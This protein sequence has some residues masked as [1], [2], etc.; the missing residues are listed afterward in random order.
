MQIIRVIFLLLIIV[1]SG[2]QH[3]HSQVTTTPS[4]SACTCTGSMSYINSTA[5]SA[6]YTLISNSGAVIS[7]DT[8]TSGT[9]GVNNLCPEV[10]VLTITQNGNTST[11]P[12]NI[13]AGAFNPGNAVSLQLCNTI[14]LTNLNNNVPGLAGGGTWTRPGGVTFSGIVNPSIDP[15]GLYTY[16]VIQGG[17]AVST[18]V[19]ISIIQNANPGQ[20]TTYLICENYVPFQML[21]FMAGSPD[22]G[23]QWFAPGGVPMN[24]IF[25]PATMNTT[26]FTYMI[27]NVPGCNPVFATMYVVENTIPNTGTDAEVLVCAGGT[28]FNMN[29]YLG[30][31]PTS[32][33]VWY[34]SSNQVVSSTFNPATQP[35]GVYRYTIDAATP[36]VDQNSFLTITFT[37]NNPSG[38][39]GSVQLCQNAPA[40]DMTSQLGGAPVP[41]G[42]WTNSSGQPV[43]NIFNPATQSSGVFNYSFQS[44]GCTPNSAQLTVSVEPL[45]NAGLNN[46]VTLCESQPNLN[47]NT[48]LSI[49]TTAGGNWLNSAGNVINPNLT[50]PAGNN[51]LSFSYNVNGVNCPGDVS[52]FTVNIQSAPLPVGDESMGLCVNDDP[53]A[54]NALYP[55]FP[56]I[57]FETTNNIPASNSFDPA[58]PG[59]YTF[60]AINPSGNVCP[61]EQGTLNITVEQPAFQSGAVSFDLCESQQTFDLNTSQQGI[62][63]PNGLWTDVAGNNIS[64]IVNLNFTGAA[65]YIFTSAQSGSC[66]QSTLEVNLNV[67][68]YVEAGA[69]SSVTLCSDATPATLGSLGGITAA[70]G[71]WFYNNQPVSFDVFDPS[72]NAAG[73][74]LYQIPANGPCPAS[75]AQLN[76]A[77][78]NGLQFSTGPDVA[79]CN[80]E[81]SVQIGQQNPLI[82]QYNWQPAQNLNNTSIA[83]PTFTIPAAGNN[84]TAYSYSVIATDGI[85][86]AV[87]TVNITVYPHPE[88]SL[89]PVYTIC[90]GETVMWQLAVGNTYNWSPSSLFTD[91]SSPIQQIAPTANTSVNIEAENNWGCQSSAEIDVIVNPVPEINFDFEP[92]AGCPPHEVNFSLDDSSTH[93]DELVWIIPGEIQF[94]G[95]SLNTG[96]QN[97]G[98]Y[99][100]QIIATSDEGCSSEITLSDLI[101]VY[102]KPRA[103]FYNEPVK[104]STIDPIGGFVNESV[105]AI[106]YNWTFDQ[107]GTSND[108]NPSFEFPSDEPRNFEICLEA[109]NSEG[110][111]DTLCRFLQ[112]ENEYILFAPNTFSPDNDGVNDTF[113]PIIRGFDESTYTLRIFDRW[114]NLVFQTN[115]SDVPW[116]G[117]VDGGSYYVQPDTYVWRIDV[118]DL[119]IADFRTFGGHITVIR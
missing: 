12:L 75:T 5:G 52:I 74:Y 82:T 100:L 25:D 113:L 48:L 118:K 117:N 83:S 93:I 37:G 9:F 86:T 106:S 32:G 97:T 36:C 58:S 98:I 8:N 102:A 38:T 99:D 67:F 30:G 20:S 29:N 60:Y 109:I 57:Q 13:A 41:G 80:D 103:D 31:N 92:T 3:L 91:P 71:N 6:T 69:T 11:I 70:G 112:L 28:A 35:A 18:G 101:E 55:A 19:F 39:N 14:G 34:N 4:S 54:L 26:L 115:K 94:A 10:Y 46:T 73:T 68:E 66:D 53:I 87:D 59:N 119:E 108:V 50:L 76:I 63:F 104:I 47:L 62:I 56:N 95:D 15:G 51:Q 43:S 27:D 114:G 79:V 33:G 16:T 85:C 89:A 61:D 42:N 84:F 17:C 44:V 78:Q 1:A 107:Y 81:A 111:A 49:G 110:C 45:P 96:I 105:G 40:F 22:P 2:A 21:T 65:E 64:N 72:T 7:T 23:G 77:V 116:T 90:E 24:G 88:I